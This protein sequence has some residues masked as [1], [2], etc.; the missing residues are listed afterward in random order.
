M[1]GD[2]VDTDIIF[3]K[4]L[5]AISFLVASGVNNFL[6]TD[7]AD[8]QLHDFSDVIPLIIKNS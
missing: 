8:H 3:G 7:M 1:I 6:D 2:R 4:S 5:N